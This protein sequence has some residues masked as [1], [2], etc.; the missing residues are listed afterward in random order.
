MTMQEIIMIGFIIGK[1]VSPANTIRVDFV[2]YFTPDNLRKYGY[3]NLLTKKEFSR[4]R[5]ESPPLHISLD[6][7]K[8]ISTCRS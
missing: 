5:T 1:D 6:L 8:S 2:L 4:M 7:Q 3:P